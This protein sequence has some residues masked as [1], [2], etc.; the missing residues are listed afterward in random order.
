M[1]DKYAD[2]PALQQDIVHSTLLEELLFW[3]FE[4]E[5]PQNFVCFLLNMLPDPNYKVWTNLVANLAPANQFSLRR[6]N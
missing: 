4:Y 6:S 3:T 2:F 5:F 1:P